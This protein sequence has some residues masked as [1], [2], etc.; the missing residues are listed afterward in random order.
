[1]TILGQ[2]T[3]HGRSIRTTALDLLLG[4]QPDAIPRLAKLASPIEH[5]D[6]KDPPLL[7][8]HGDQDPQVPIEQS[9]ELVDKYKSSKLPHHFE[10]I[11]GGQHGGDRFFDEQRQNAIHEFL[12]R[13]LE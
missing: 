3:A 10:I 1:M 5:V 8:I 4:A 6:A 7:V 11:P 2:S 12:E 9:I 13:H